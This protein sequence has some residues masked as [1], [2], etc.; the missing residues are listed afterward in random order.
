MIFSL[1]AQLRK[2]RWD[3]VGSASQV[4]IHQRYGVGKFELKWAA[5]A[6]IQARSGMWSSR[7]GAEFPT[8]CLH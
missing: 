7:N 2:Y 5:V 6:S 8:T 1:V 4:L 3:A